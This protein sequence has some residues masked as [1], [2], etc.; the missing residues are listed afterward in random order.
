[1]TGILRN[2]DGDLMIAGGSLQVGD[3][4]LQVAEVVILSATGELKHAP[5]IGGNLV[6]AING[7]VDGFMINRLKQM[8]KAE[9]VTVKK[10]SISGSTITI[11][12]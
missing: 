1:M 2:T 9:G 11:E 8:L 6:M 7:T 10:L 5:M 4:Q 3:V 12:L